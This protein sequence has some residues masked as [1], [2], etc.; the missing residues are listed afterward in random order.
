MVEMSQ[1][2]IVRLGRW[3]GL[4]PNPLRRRWDRIEAAG[5][6][7]ALIGLV[8]S[9]VAGIIVATGTYQAHQRAAQHEAKSSYP[10][11]ARLLTDP[12]M[13]NPPP[14]ASPGRPAGAGFAQARWTAPDGSVRQGTIPAAAVWRAGQ[15]VAIRVDA[16]GTPVGDNR[17]NRFT[18]LSAVMMAISFPIGAAALLWL[19]LLGVRALVERRTLREWEDEWSIVEPRWRKRII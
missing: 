4:G 8:M 19:A 14:A 3:L 5:R 16:S 15:D 2:A 9:V 12:A 10:A 1:N 7:A 17:P 6:V 11:T 13:M 18:P